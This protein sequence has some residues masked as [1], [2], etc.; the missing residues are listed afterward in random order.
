MGRTI[1]RPRDIALRE[2]SLGRFMFEDLYVGSGDFDAI[3][4]QDHE[5]EEANP[6]GDVDIGRGQ[7]KV[8]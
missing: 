2:L 7:L 8:R 3:L 4:D 1:C 6:P 5:E